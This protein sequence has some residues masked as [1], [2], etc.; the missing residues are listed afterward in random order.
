MSVHTTAPPEPAMKARAENWKKTAPS[1]KKS[2]D[3]ISN[4]YLYRKDA[5]AGNEEDDIS[6]LL[7]DNYASDF[8]IPIVFN[9]AVKYNMQWF[10]GEKRK[11]FGN[12]LKRAKQYV[13]VIKDILR[14]NG[15]PEDLV[16]LAMIESGFNPKAY[17][18]AKASGPWQFIYATGERY[19]LKVNYWIDERRDPE[20]STV[21]A[22]KYLRDLFNQFGCWYL[23]A[24]GYNAGERR[25]EKAIEKHNTNDFWELVKYNTLPRET[26]EYIPR[27]IAAAVIAK[28]PEKFGFGSM[29]YDQPIQFAEL[30]VPGGTPLTAVAKAA[31][32]DV[33]TVRS[34]NPEI[35]RGITPPNLE[36]YTI[37]LPAPVDIQK[38]AGNLKTAMSGQR[39]VRGLI[40]YKV[41][42]QDTIAKIAKRYKVSSTDICLVNGFEDMPKVKPGM[43]I[44][45]PKY[46]GPIR[47]QPER[48]KNVA[49]T[50]TAS[51]PAKAGKGNLQAQE[52]QKAYHVVKKGETLM[53]I[54][55]KYGID[56]ASL[57][58]MN[59]LKNDK[60]YPN[61]KL[62]L[63]GHSQKKQTPKVQYH[64]V[65]KGETL[66]SI[67]DKYG[68]DV[69]SLKSLNKLKSNKI[70]AK[71]KLKIPR[72]EG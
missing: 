2:A 31:S 23:A 37:K 71:M 9:D 64:V 69:A 57:R 10:T 15:M 7:E 28:D 35:I 59:S 18:T 12:W 29:S 33:A 30:N 66:G 61:M 38:F 49:K 8:D 24:A 19:G 70:S 47:T 62:K 25:I 3:R 44:Q 22:A 52:K 68:T 65:K 20:K 51:R 39:K 6:A 67:S 26:R 27:L 17:S 72:N 58:S 32:L 54:S 5:P 14:K 60:V 40:A 42:R 50:R 53:S 11:V 56:V 1:G 36:L 4:D 21:A 34:Y 63:V 45:I 48:E 13:P 55:G 46:T 43:T 16:Y 41:K